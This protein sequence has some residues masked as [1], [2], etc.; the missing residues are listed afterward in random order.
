MNETAEI[1]TCDICGEEYWH[2]KSDCP[3]GPHDW[4]DVYNFPKNAHPASQRSSKYYKRH[5]PGFEEQRLPVLRRYEWQ[6]ADCGMTDK[7]HRNRDDLWPPNGGLHI[8]HKTA[9]RRFENEENAHIKINLIALCSDC[10]NK[11]E[12]G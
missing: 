10:H 11:R 9:S 7:E 5:G 1:I 3:N 12:N 6:C 2:T 4:T 8:H